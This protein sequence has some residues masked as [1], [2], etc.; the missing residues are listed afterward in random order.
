M[1]NKKTVFLVVDDFEPMRKVTATQL[2]SLGYDKVLMANNGAEAL[3]ILRKQHVDVVLSDW[4]M[5]V[6]SG[7]ELVREIRADDTLNA[8]PFIMI[9]AEAERE[10]IAEAIASGIS[11]LLVKPYSSDRLAASIDKAMAWRPRKAVTAASGKPSPETAAPITGERTG[12]RSSERQTILIVDDTP[13]MLL[14]LANLFQNEYRVRIARNGERALEICASD[15]PPD[16]ILLDIMMPEM[17]GFEVLRHLRETSSGDPIPVIFVTAMATPGAQLEGLELGAVDFVTKPVDPEVLKAR[18][19]NFLRYVEQNQRL[20]TEVDDMLETARLRHH[21]EQIVRHDIKG[22][23]AGII[24]LVQGLRDDASLSPFQ[25]EQLKAVEESAM[26]ILNLVNGSSE[27]FKIETGRYTLDPRPVKVGDILRRVIEIVRP[28]FNGK[29]LH[30][31]LVGDAN[32]LAAAEA[33]GDPMLCYSL[34]QNLV[35]NASE[36]SPENGRVVVTV[37]DG[38]P[39]R[40]V[41]ENAGVVPAEIR[42]RLFEKFVTFGKAG[43]TGLGTYSAKLLVEAQGGG[44]AVDV[45]DTENRTSITVSLPGRPAQ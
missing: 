28:V 11:D 20:Q 29:Q 24:G 30:L 39:L 26:E 27:L 37:H 45:S 33:L 43:G 17:D 21:V 13:D 23:L 19:R 14:V 15:D 40:V 3:K 7:L 32:H 8:L 6:L 36:A 9:T 22:P 31:E 18:V 12:T 44:I 25:A 5:P 42:D 2:R 38:N 10:R 1:T 41:I 16:L 4:N 34:F 35:K